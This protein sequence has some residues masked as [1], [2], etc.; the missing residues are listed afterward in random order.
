MLNEFYD[1]AVEF[2]VPAKSVIQSVDSFYEFR[3][4]LVHFL[5]WKCLV[6]AEFF[7][8]AFDPCSSTCPG[9][10][11]FVFLPNEEHVFVVFVVGKK[12]RNRFRFIKTS[13]VIEIAVLAIF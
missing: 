12:N 7:G 2:F 13:Q 4:F 3:Q 9:L 10:A 11:F 8:G 1:A 6:G 5:N